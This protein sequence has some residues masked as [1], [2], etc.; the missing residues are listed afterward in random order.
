MF[1][2]PAWILGVRV[3]IGNVVQ[4]RVVFRVVYLEFQNF[5][6]TSVAY[7]ITSFPWHE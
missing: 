3:G 7:A 5:E 4:V 6:T 1:L 2:R